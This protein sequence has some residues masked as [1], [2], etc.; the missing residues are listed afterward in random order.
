MPLLSTLLL[1]LALAPQEAETLTASSFP[2]VFERTSEDG[3]LTVRVHEAIIGFNDPAMN[4]ESFVTSPD[5][6]RVAYMVMVGQGLAVTVD[7][8]TGE[9]FEGVARNSIVFSPDGQHVGYVGT[10]P[11]QQCAVLDGKIFAYEGVARQG[12]V[13]SPDGRHSGWI[14]EREGNQLAVIDE[15]EG[16]PFQ[17]ISPIGIL[18]SPDSARHAYVALSGEKQLAVVDGVEGPLFDLVSGLRFSPDGKVAAYVGVR[19][20]KWYVVAEDR[21]M[22]PYDAVSSMTMDVNSTKDFQGIVFPQRGSRVGFL[23]TRGGQHYAV[24][25]GQENGPYENCTKLTFSPDGSRVAFLATEGEGLFLVLDGEEHRDAAF[26]GL[27]FSSDGKRCAVVLRRGDQEIVSVDGVE[28]PPYHKIEL[29][30]FSP[31]GSRMAYVASDGV[32][33][34]IVLDGKPSEPLRRFGK[35]PLTFLEG[36]QRAVW[37]IRKAGGEVMVV[38]GVEGP[39]S[40]GLRSIAFSADG[41]HVAYASQRRPDSWTVVV[42]GVEYGP[43][44]RIDDPSDPTW[45]LVGKQTPVFSPDGRR[46]AC[47]AQERNGRFVVVTSDGWRSAEFDLVMKGTVTFTPDGAHLLFIAGRGEAETGQRYI[48]VDGMEIGNGWHGFLQNSSFQFHSPTSFCMRALRNPRNLL[49]E[50]EITGS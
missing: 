20:G 32:E 8:E 49:V 43:E 29:V 36:S 21:E 15:V 3:R 45:K 14:G 10:R 46:W 39:A 25:D 19:E 27:F 47:S 11:G 40:Q 12:I 22:G 6:H 31:D 13:F 2:T 28:T 4:Q 7:G 33:K 50:L 23:A 9:G 37:S 16:P 5:G 30:Q 17:G 18:F 44:G 42:D 38:E 41:Q 48:V 24:V 35:V 1:P 26:Q 34:T